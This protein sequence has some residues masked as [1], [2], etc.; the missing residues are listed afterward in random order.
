M[1]I[2]NPPTRTAHRT[3]ALLV[4]L[5]AATLAV[6]LLL[7]PTPSTDTA[8]ALRDID[9]FRDRYVLTN[10]I[11]LVGILVMAAGLLA[12]ARVQLAVGGG[13][14][15]LL[16]GAANA[17]GGGLIAL[18]VVLQSSVDVGV[19][20]RFVD[21]DGQAQAAHLAVA[22]AVFEINGA[23]FG[24][25]FLLQ[26]L[27]IALVAATFFLIPAPRLNRPFLIVGALLAGTAS[28][29]GIGALFDEIFGRLEAL[30]G[31]VA[32]VWLIVL[33]GMLWRRAD[34]AR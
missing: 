7:G 13:L 30:L 4:A 20:E 23:I 31:L 5:G 16:G 28:V 24:V 6:G 12:L 34:D 25:G 21:A 14:P 2:A 11:D 26:M 1:E 3:A 19:A 9:G 18:V 22:E 15:A 8:E 17:L 33:S 32:L 10:A 27:G 29:M